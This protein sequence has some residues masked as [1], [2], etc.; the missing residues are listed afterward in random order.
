[1]HTE[2]KQTITI[3]VHARSMQNSDVNICTSQGRLGQFICRGII[4]LLIIR[5]AVTM[6]LQFDPLK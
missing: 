2:Y 5:T 6:Y 4:T 3:H 1:M